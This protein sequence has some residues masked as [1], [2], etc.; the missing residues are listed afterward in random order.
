MNFDKILEGKN[1]V[2]EDTNIKNIIELYK[3]NINEIVKVLEKT[4]FKMLIMSNHANVLKDNYSISVILSDYIFDI[5]N[6]IEKENNSHGLVLLIHQLMEESNEVKSR[7]MIKLFTL[8]EKFYESL[9]RVNLDTE[10]LEQY[11]N[12][13]KDQLNDFLLINTD[14]VIDLIYSKVNYDCSFRLKVED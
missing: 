1:E 14:Y 3:I 6:Y 9:E 10:S 11:Y 2:N 4:I 8:L 13:V 12:G 5:F 7:I